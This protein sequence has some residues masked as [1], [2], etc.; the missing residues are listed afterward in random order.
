MAVMVMGLVVGCSSSSPELRAT[1]AMLQTQQNLSVVPAPAPAPASVPALASAPLP[2]APSAAAEGEPFVLAAQ[3][4]DLKIMT[5]NLRVPFILDGWNFW[6]FRRDLIVSTVEKF[7]PDILGTQECPRSSAEYLESKLTEY[8]FVGV[9]RN[10]GKLRGE[11]VGMFFRRDR[12]TKTH[13]GHFWLS[14]TPSKA[15]SKS[16]GNGAPRMVSW[17]TLQPKDGSATFCWFNTHFDNASGHSRNESAKLL[18]AEVKQIAGN[19]P[20]VVTGDFNADQHTEPYE[21]LVGGR[22]GID[23]DLYDAFRLANPIVNDNEGTMHNFHGG[24]NGPRIDW[25]LTNAGFQP[26]DVTIDHTQRGPLFPSDHFP[27]KA[28]VRFNTPPAP[29]NI[30]KAE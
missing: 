5:F 14:N 29:T 17:V 12:F 4:N 25:I 7:Q 16:W 18:R 23:T 22:P 20:A 11:M 13:E 8:D 15:G 24:K 19:M 1:N 26:L 28:I 3:P 21:L 2:A 6:T 9:G 30:A 10:D 27:V